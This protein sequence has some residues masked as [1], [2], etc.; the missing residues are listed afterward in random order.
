MGS[1]AMRK[2]WCIVWVGLVLAFCLAG[3]QGLFPQPVYTP[4]VARLPQPPPPPP[5]VARPTFYVA[6]RNTL[7]LRAGPGMDFFMLAVLQRNEEVEKVGESGDWSQIRV[8]RDGTIGWVN[9]RYLSPNPVAATPE[10]AP[11][12]IP[13][14]AVTPPPLPEIP[15]T[16]KPTP[17]SPPA[18]EKPPKAAKPWE[19][20]APA[21]RKPEEAQPPRRAKPKPAEPEEEEE[22]EP[23]QPRRVKPEKPAPEPPAVKPTPPATPEP[24]KPGKIRI[25]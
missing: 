2:S 5:P 17:P 14:E 9:S 19:T 12:S 20:P 23:E 15:A 21:I 25:M 18:V 22:A 3:C 7:N 8:K 1:A 6:V 10:V 4:P 24:E 16:P 13:P 11:P